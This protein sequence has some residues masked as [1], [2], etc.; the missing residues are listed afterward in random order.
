MLLKFP[1]F[2]TSIQQ[3]NLKRDQISEISIE[4]KELN[5]LHGLDLLCNDIH[6]FPK[7]P[8]SLTG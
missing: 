5:Q 4:I 1:K 3:I 2:S 7:I 8:S 6:I